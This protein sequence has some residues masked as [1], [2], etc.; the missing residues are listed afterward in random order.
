MFK[1]PDPELQIDF[2]VALAEIRK[3]YLQDALSETVKAIDITEVDRQLG[4]M[5]PKASLS[6]LASHGLRGE[7]MFPVP[8]LLEANPRLLG[9]YRLLM[10]SARRDFTPPKPESRASRRWKSAGFSHQPTLRRSPTFAKPSSGPAL[11]FW[12]A[13]APAASAADFWTTSP[14]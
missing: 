8:H 14:C 4:A 1:I 2:S 5:V 3:L 9:Y 13:S 7:L 11:R 10:G 12:M 6:A